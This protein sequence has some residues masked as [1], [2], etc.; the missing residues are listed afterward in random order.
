MHPKKVSEMLLSYSK[1]HQIDHQLLLIR[2]FQERILYRVSISDFKDKLLL[3]GGIFLY[4][5][6]E[7]KS[8]PTIDIDFLAHTISNDVEEI[9]QIF[10]QILSMHEDDGVIFD[11]HSILATVINEQ[12]QY[13]GVRLKVLANLGNIKQNIQIDIGFGDIVTLYV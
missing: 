13:V 8:R 4:S 5:I 9:K 3:K 11:Y 10:V 12:N 7:N 6:Q 2:F 1:N